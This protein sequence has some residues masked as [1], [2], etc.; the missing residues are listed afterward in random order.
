MHGKDG[1]H[2][3]HR[4]HLQHLRKA[5]PYAA[6]GAAHSEIIVHDDD[7]LGSPTPMQGE[8]V[9]VV[10]PRGGSGVVL[11]LKGRTLSDVDH[12]NVLPMRSGKEGGQGG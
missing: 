9:Q 6:F 2:L 8:V 5:K 7:P 3:T 10:L 4:H 11:D 1:T 12:G